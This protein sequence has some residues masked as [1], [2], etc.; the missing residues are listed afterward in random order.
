[1][2]C[3]FSKGKDDAQKK[4]RGK[5]ALRDNENVRMQYLEDEH[6]VMIKGE[7]CTEI[8][9]YVRPLFRDQAHAFKEQIG[10]SWGRAGSTQ[11]QHFYHKIE[12]RFFEF[13]LCDAHWKA[14]QLATDNYAGYKQNLKKREKV[15]KEETDGSDHRPK[16]ETSENPAAKR[17]KKER[18]SSSEAAGTA[19]TNAASATANTGIANAANTSTAN[20]STTGTGIAN[21]GD[22]SV[23][24]AN[25]ANA[26]GV[27]ASTGD[28]SIG[29]GLANASIGNTTTRIT[30][31]ANP[32]AALASIANTNDAIA[33]NTGTRTPAS[34]TRAPGSPTTRTPAVGSRAPR[35][36]PGSGHGSYCELDCSSGSW[37]RANH[38]IQAKRRYHFTVA[39]N[40]PHSQV[41]F[42]FHSISVLN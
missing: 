5:A 41:Y 40:G 28:T 23:P 33:A 26:G 9:D 2:A 17:R 20:A 12:N 7:Q 38:T 42:R 24:N 1:V 21:A 15:I 36:A 29:I 25:A 27:L 39:G 37:S 35:T 8:L 30:N 6:G 34:G 10:T 32:S 16:Q 3:G 31:D 18:A 4:N 19:N 11:Q 13:R 22:T 14:K